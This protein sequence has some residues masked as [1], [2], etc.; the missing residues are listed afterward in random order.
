MK[1]HTQT[2]TCLCCWQ[3]DMVMKKMIWWTKMVN[4]PGTPTNW[5][6]NWAQWKACLGSLNCWSYKL[7][8]Q[9]SRHA[10]NHLKLTFEQQLTPFHFSSL[11]G[12]EKYQNTT[13]PQIMVDFQEHGTSTVKVWLFLLREKATWQMSTLPMLQFMDTSRN[14]LF[15]ETLLGLLLCVALVSVRLLF[16]EPMEVTV[17]LVQSSCRVW[18]KVCWTT[19]RVSHLMTHSLKSERLS[20]TQSRCC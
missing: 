15:P 20:R 18:L 4:Q 1:K 14:P 10:T 7:A 11:G 6:L 19:T 17:R 16:A 9:V 8:G 12:I 13:L 3:F 2:P 5:L